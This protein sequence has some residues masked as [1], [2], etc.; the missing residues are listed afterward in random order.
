M[1]VSAFSSRREK[2]CHNGGMVVA[3]QPV[4]A[5][6]GSDI[7]QRGLRSPSWPVVPKKPHFFPGNIWTWS[8]YLPV[9]WRQLLRSRGP[10]PRGSRRAGGALPARHRLSDRSGAGSHRPRSPCASRRPLLANPRPTLGLAGRR[11][12]RNAFVLYS[13]PRRRRRPTDPS[14]GA[15]LSRRETPQWSLRFSVSREAVTAIVVRTRPRTR[16]TA[17]RLL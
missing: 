16:F 6:R 3:H 1:G 8:V 4:G 7:G 5:S 14:L 2:Y 17:R 9:K 11:S 15:A 10:S 13:G 12:A